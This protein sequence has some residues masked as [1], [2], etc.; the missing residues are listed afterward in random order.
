MSIQFNL[1]LVWCC[2]WLQAHQ[3]AA[4][5]KSAQER[6]EA[7]LAAAQ[8]DLRQMQASRLASSKWL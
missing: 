8:S 6:A 7:A 2:L 4:A 1:F 3:E 5:A